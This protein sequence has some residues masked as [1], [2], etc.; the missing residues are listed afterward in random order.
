MVD[1]RAAIE[2]FEKAS[3]RTIATCADVP[4]AAWASRPKPDQHSMAEVVEHMAL[5][6]ALFAGRLRKIIA[7]PAGETA[8]A[9]L[10]DDEIPH[11][12]ERVAEPPGIA[13]PSGAWVDRDDA[14]ARFEA[15][16]ADVIAASASDLSDNALR[17]RGAPHPLFGPL[18]GV[19]WALFAA[20][21]TERHR[22]EL[23]RLKS[24]QERA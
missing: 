24:L 18:D 14:L 11:L 4:S 1:F 20:A 7:S 21:H 13:E 22:S 3:W 2:K 23:I 10:D 5:S 8:H 17:V 9:V 6:N 15:S 12:F 16:A 19:Q